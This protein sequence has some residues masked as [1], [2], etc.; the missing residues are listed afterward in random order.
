MCLLCKNHP[1]TANA[2]SYRFNQEGIR[3]AAKFEQIL[4]APK[5][6]S[7]EDLD[8]GIKARLEAVTSWPTEIDQT[9]LKNQIIVFGSRVEYANPREAI[10]SFS[11]LPRES[12]CFFDQV[13]SM[14]INSF[15]RQEM[16]IN[17]VPH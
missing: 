6:L 9:A 10:I 3:E 4:M 13:R 16:Y 1:V 2:P 12:R 17:N 8:V 15:K 5:E 11:N 7:K 14:F